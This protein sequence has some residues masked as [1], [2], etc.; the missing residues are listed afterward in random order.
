MKTLI[1]LLLSVMVTSLCYSQDIR[2]VEY[3]TEFNIS[4]SVKW[5]DE[6]DSCTVYRVI[7]SDDMTYKLTK[8]H[9][10]VM[11]PTIVMYKD[12]IEVIRFEAD[13]MME[14]NVPMDTIRYY[15]SSYY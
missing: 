7:V 10:I 4:N 2:V 5:L 13:I 1:S 11:Y 15:I 14:L 6:L 9:N 8:K 12:S 3:N